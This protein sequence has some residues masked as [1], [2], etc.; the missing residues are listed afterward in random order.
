M[1]KNKKKKLDET[2]MKILDV[3]ASMQG[4]I[5]FHDPVNLR[6]NGSFDGKLDTKGRLS[7]G[8]SAVVNADITGD[9]IS[10]AGKVVGNIFASQSVAI[11]APGKVQGDVSTPVLS[12]TEGAVING[13]IDMNFKGSKT[14][15]DVLTLQEVA[16]YLELE[17]SVLEEWA[18]KK[19]VPAVHDGETWRFSKAAIDKW[20]QEEKVTV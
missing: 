1:A 4:T 15:S 17:T 12:I 20:V 18:Q 13:V 9:E 11:V 2:D 3:D 5:V 19:K 16:H 14:G 6:I 10:I 7:I 8:E